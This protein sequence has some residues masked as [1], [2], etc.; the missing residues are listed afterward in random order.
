M[1]HALEVAGDALL[2]KPSVARMY[3]YFLGGY[4][5]FAVDRLA[6]QQ[7][8]GIY[9]DVMLMARTNRAFLR[10]AVTTLLEQGVE[11]FLDLGSG[12]PTVGSV[13]EVAQQ[14]E[15][16]A[17]V[18]YV[19]IDP[20]AVQ[21]SEAILQGQPDVAVVQA[22]IREPEYILGHA[23]VTRLIDFSKPVGVLLV[24]VIH[25]VDDAAARQVVDAFRD[26][27][28]PGSYLVLSHVTYEGPPPEAVEQAQRIYANSTNPIIFR[29][30][31]HI[32][33]FLGGFEIVEPGVVYVPQWRP[34]GPNMLGLA[35]PE[36]TAFFAGVGRK[37]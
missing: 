24:A 11:Q 20:V 6:A 15:R 34:Q 33:S 31:A 21:H 25:F 10:R 12:I 14:L 16:D 28:A 23:A 4:H 30:H 37:L 7:V 36:R 35:Q 5:N 18:V 9:P 32:E 27:I 26:A 19:D 8:I 13:H 3:D 1:D 17:R 2:E 22:D 29:S